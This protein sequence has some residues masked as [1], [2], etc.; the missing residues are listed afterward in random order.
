MKITPLE[1]PDVKLIEPLVHRDARGFFLETFRAGACEEAGIPTRWVQDNHSRSMCG[2]LR[3]LHFQRAHPQ[4]KLVRVAAGEVLD[5]A[6]D[7]RASSP[8]FGKWVGTVLSDENH[9][10]LY[11]PR[12]FAHGFVVR[13]ASADLCYKCDEYYV[14]GDQ[15]GVAWNDPDLSIDWGVDEP[16]LSE[17]DAALPLLKEIEPL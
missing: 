16:L 1:I 14:P 17:T 15:C 13:S 8:T 3:G 4:G 2:V 11:I 12:G 10:Q 5:V 7:L 6:V 9:H